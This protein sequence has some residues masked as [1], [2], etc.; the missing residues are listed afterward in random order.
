MP[1]AGLIKDQLNTETKNPGQT[2]ASSIQENHHPALLSILAN[3]LS[4]APEEIHDF[5]LYVSH[6]LGVHH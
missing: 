5:E 1:I 2:L 6:C 4:V 3:E